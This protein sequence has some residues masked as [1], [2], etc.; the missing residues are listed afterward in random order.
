[1]RHRLSLLILCASLPG[2][3]PASQAASSLGSPVS[4]PTTPLSALDGSTT[5][6]GSVL[7]GRPALVALWATWCDACV[8]ETRALNQLEERARPDGSAVV[9]GV[10]V[11]ETRETV[12]AFA[13]SH[14]LG[15]RLLVDEEFRVADALGERRVPTTLVVDRRGRIVYR[16]GA[17]DRAGLAAFRQ[18]LAEK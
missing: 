11:G 2:C 14:G 8:G 5:D 6:L 7:R 15:Y 18:V 9:V 3:A 17:L 1:M 4:I 16:G 10:A 13:E 12:D